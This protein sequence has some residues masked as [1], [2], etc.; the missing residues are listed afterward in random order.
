VRLSDAR[1]E[2]SQFQSRVNVVLSLFS[3]R[4]I[5]EI[6]GL[7]ALA[8]LLLGVW[9][10]WRRQTVLADIEEDVKNIKLTSEQAW[11]KTKW[12][13]F[14]PPVVITLGVLLMIAAMVMYARH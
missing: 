3:S 4:P 5:W 6:T 1:A 2:T 7:C 12:V 13:N 10:S 8:L 14:G 9:M 11:R